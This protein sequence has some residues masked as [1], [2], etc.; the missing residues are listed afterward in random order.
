MSLTAVASAPSSTSL[1]SRLADIT[2]HICTQVY[3]RTVETRLI[4]LGAL[5]NE[6]VFFHGPPGCA[7]TEMVDLF[8]QAITGAE[9]FGTQFHPNKPPE[10]L[11]GR[12]DLLKFTQTGQLMYDT[13]GHLPSCHFFKA[14]EIWKG[15][16][17]NHDPM[18]SIFNERVF[19]ND[20]TEQHCPLIMALGTSNEFPESDE[21]VALYDRFLIRKQVSYLKEKR[22]VVK[23]MNRTDAPLPSPVTISL[24][25]LYQAQAEVAAVTFPKQ[26]MDLL[27]QIR[28]KLQG[29][30]IIPSDRRVKKAGKVLRANAWLNGR[31][32]VDED[33]MDVLRHIFWDVPEQV[34]AVDKIVLGTSSP[35]SQ[36]L[37]TILE[38]LNATAAGVAERKG[39]SEQ[40]L[41]AF[42]ATENSKIKDWTVQ[43]A[44]LEQK[45]N[46]NGR[47]TAKLEETKHRLDEVRAIVFAECLGVQL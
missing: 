3:E 17:A 1:S 11:F 45:M 16:P 18:L 35:D 27:I 8:A 31:S 34:A 26:S 4:V 13:T 33:D 23:L 41:M 30:H 38:G 2:K 15:N 42:G 40:S 7:K 28:T 44:E 14:D 37:I 43:L 9:I 46:A 20:G 47:S 29:E 25:E 19:F 12:Q 21:S 5:T 24:Q 36:A 32:A 10:S 6:H 22:N 39:Q